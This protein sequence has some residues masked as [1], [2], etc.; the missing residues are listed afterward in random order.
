M[1]YVGV[2]EY[3]ETGM[4]SYTGYGAS[5]CG[6]DSYGC[7]CSGYG[8]TTV[9]TV[10]VDAIM[11]DIAKS[12]V[13]YGPAGACAGAQSSSPACKSVQGGCNAAG[14]RANKAIAVALNQ[15]GYGPIAVDGTISWQSAYSSFLSDHGLTKGPGF[16]ITRQAL[17]TMKQELEAGNKP[18]PA[19]KT[20]YEKV[21]GEYVPK[22]APD[23][24]SAIGGAK[25]LLAA[26]VVGG[27][28][29]AV[30]RAGKKKKTAQSYAGPASA[31]ALTMPA[32]L[33]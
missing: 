17:M 30:Y 18:G 11:A 14:Q 15:L 32:R 29:Y 16:G 1:S 5:G 7:G 9:S 23:A 10:D 12:D 3:Y 2:G 8:A 31:G 13:C 4:G 20:E 26:V 22:S 21:N 25:W 19:P 33:A 24:L 27:L 28:G 6:C